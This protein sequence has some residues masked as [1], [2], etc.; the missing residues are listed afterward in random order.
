[1]DGGTLF[2]EFS[3]GWYPLWG[4]VE[5]KTNGQLTIL[6]LPKEKTR[7]FY[8]CA[9]TSPCLGSAVTNKEHR[10]YPLETGRK[11]WMQKSTHKN[12]GSMLTWNPASQPTGQDVALFPG[13]TCEPPGLRAV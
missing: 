8:P 5:G 2:L 7:P 11:V 4:G 3:F 10:G 9:L 12:Q 6:G 1:M 13:N